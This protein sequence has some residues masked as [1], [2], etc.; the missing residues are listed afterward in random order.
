MSV[1]DQFR[2]D[3]RVVIVTGGASGIGLAFASAVAEA[4]ADVAIVDINLE[5]A[6]VAADKLSKETGRRV[7]ALKAD[8]S[9]EEDNGRMVSETLKMLGGLD[10]CF[11]NAGIGELGA[12]ILDYD[13]PKWKRTITV[14]LTGTFL[15]NRAVA[16]VMI[17]QKSGVI[18]NTASAYGL[19]GD[20]CL[21]VIGYTASK[22]G[23]V[24]LTRTMAAQLAPYGIRVNAVAPGF[25]R[26]NLGDGI[27][28]EDVEDPAI[29]AVHEQIAGRTL[30]KR[31]AQPEELKGIA[32]F[33]AS[34]ASSYC[35]G[36]TYAVDG[37]W[38]AV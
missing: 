38:L 36:Y 15:T 26:T 17:E 9:K 8:V 25:T 11:A 13:T 30:L 14:N 16:K 4:G 31:F 12:P 19:I 18:I 1:L 34:D 7:I 10:I 23:V 22:G 24:Q 32:L 27:L 20:G 2:L 29:L 35:T 21:G 37:G 5:G 6:E 3:G 28:H 33:L